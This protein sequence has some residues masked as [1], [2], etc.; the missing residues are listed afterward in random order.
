M[1]QKPV[2]RNQRIQIIL[3]TLAEVQTCSGCATRFR[4]GDLECPHCGQDLDDQ[5]L[6]V[7]QDLLDRLAVE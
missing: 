3:N 1:T 5:L 6:E 7:A 4:F 2:D